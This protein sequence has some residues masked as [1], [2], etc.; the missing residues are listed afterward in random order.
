M[1]MAESWPTA[2]SVPD[3]ESI[4]WIRVSL[5]NEII[6]GALPVAARPLDVWNTAMKMSA[7]SNGQTA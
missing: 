1:S 7:L 2:L 5:L 3:P 6:C 4:L